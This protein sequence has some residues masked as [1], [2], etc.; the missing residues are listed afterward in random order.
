[1]TGAVTMDVCARSDFKSRRRTAARATAIIA[2]S[3]AA[4]MACSN[5]VYIDGQVEHVCGAIINEPGPGMQDGVAWYHDLSGSGAHP[6]FELPATANFDY[7]TSPWIQ[8]SHSCSHGATATIEPAGLIKIVDT[9]S[10]GKGL[11]TAVRLYAYVPGAVT[12]SVHRDGKLVS[13]TKITV[14]VLPGAQYSR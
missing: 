1:V 6:G 3:V 11:Y 5:S 2:L 10:G 4:L 9:V 7:G 12:L 13:S 8:I 14:V